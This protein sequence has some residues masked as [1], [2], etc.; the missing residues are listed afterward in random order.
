MPATEKGWPFVR[1]WMD[2]LMF[3][4]IHTC[5]LSLVRICRTIFIQLQ[6]F[7]LYTVP[8]IRDQLGYFLGLNKYH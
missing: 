7:S 8:D 3:S 1:R 6:V 2:P 4:G 5:T